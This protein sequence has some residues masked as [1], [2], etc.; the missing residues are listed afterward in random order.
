MFGYARQLF[1]IYRERFKLVCEPYVIRY[2]CIVICW[3]ASQD[4]VLFE[5]KS[6]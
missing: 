6:P 2:W 1:Q 4:D 5:T 3:R